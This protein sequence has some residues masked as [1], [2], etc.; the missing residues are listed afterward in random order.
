[1]RRTSTVIVIGLLAALVFAYGLVKLFGARLSVGDTLP[2]YSSLRADPVGT[3]AL[4]DAAAR[5]P[6]VRTDRNFR[7]LDAIEADSQT[8]VLLLGVVLYGD[9]NELQEEIAEEIES[10]AGEGARV[11]LAFM[12]Q[13]REPG[14]S[15]FLMPRRPGD[16]QH[17]EENGAEDGD[18]AEQE[19]GEEEETDSP[20]GGFMMPALVDLPE[21]WGL[22]LDYDDLPLKALAD[23]APGE[24]VGFEF[25]VAE[26][27]EPEDRPGLP[28][29]FEVRT[30]LYFETLDESW[31]TLYARDAGAV[32]VER[33]WGDG[34]LVL[35]ADAYLFS[36][37][38]LAED[39]HTPYLLYAMGEPARV[40]FDES[41][42]GLL[43]RPS[44]MTLAR[45]MNMQ[46]FV[47]GLLL[48]AILLIW[49]G[50]SSLAPRQGL[51]EEDGPAS[52]GRSAAEGLAALLRRSVPE[53]RLL[54]VCAEEWRQVQ[55][56][57]AEAPSGPEVEGL[58]GADL[59]RAYKTVAREVH[60][61]RR[62]L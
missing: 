55:R 39:R 51:K 14:R 27:Q 23:D 3:K 60:E 37:E 56:D 24:E 22:R 42:K 9:V 30:G 17:E 5:L 11:V 19:D 32:V 45:R 1:M 13:P 40:I 48:F 36:N 49:H 33:P 35:V 8:T 58:K 34:S 43:D 6:G 61:R 52:E 41:L 31:R 57:E 20:A 38:G 46:G 62:R 25:A 59:V 44:L 21:R 16:V 4:H 50:A 28:R 18:D 12:P 10:M 15:N 54:K 47:A 26:L 2:P 7:P 53:D 29:T